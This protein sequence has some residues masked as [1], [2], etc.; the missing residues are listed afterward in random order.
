MITCLLVKRIQR[1]EYIHIKRRVR[2]GRVELTR[3]VEE[4]KEVEKDSTPYFEVHV[5][6]QGEH[7]TDFAF[8]EGEKSQGTKTQPRPA[9]VKRDLKPDRKSLVKLHGHTRPRLYPIED[10]KNS[11]HRRRQV[12]SKQTNKQPLL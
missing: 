1:T 2:L 9:R 10:G 7:R 12:A 8:R 3:Q 11:W 4:E 5:Q 6:Q